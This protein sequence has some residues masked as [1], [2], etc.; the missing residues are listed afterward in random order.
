MRS[1]SCGA[2]FQTVV[3]ERYCR[4]ETSVEEAMME[5]YLAGVSTKRI[6]DASEILWDS[7]VS[8]GA[9]SNLNE[10]AFKSVEE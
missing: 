7:E 6:E 2:T 3:I 5:M 1:P 9:V 8:V 4:R 10:R